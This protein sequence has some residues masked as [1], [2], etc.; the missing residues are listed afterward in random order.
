MPVIENKNEE[1]EGDSEVTNTEVVSPPDMDTMDNEPEDQDLEFKSDQ[2][3]KEMWGKKAHIK[4]FKSL[5]SMANENPIIIASFIKRY[6]KCIK[7]ADPI[8]SNKLL[9]LAQNI[10][11]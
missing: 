5:Q 11:K 10:G 2:I 1:L 7:N 4:F 8:A 9:K 3:A 6:A